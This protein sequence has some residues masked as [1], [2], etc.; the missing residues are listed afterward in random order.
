MIKGDGDPAEVSQLF[1]AIGARLEEMD[2]KV[3]EH[4][5]YVDI[6]EKTGRVTGPPKEEA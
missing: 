2:Q 4:N 6:G 5:S 3:T 1:V